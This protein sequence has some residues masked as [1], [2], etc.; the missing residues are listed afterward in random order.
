LEATCGV[1]YDPVAGSNQRFQLMVN[2][3]GV[4]VA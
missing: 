2:N 3:D 1:E 4:I